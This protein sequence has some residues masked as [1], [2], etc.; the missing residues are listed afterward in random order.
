MHSQ[1]ENILN[2]ILSRR[3]RIGRA[4]ALSQETLVMTRF[5]PKDAQVAGLR[6]LD[7]PSYQGVNFLW[8]MVSSCIVLVPWPASECPRV[9]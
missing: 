8:V 7:V 6:V 3:K 9:S 1:C 4:G 5:V 2:F